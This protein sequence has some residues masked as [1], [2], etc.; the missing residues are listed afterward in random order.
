[1]YSLLVGID[2]CKDFFA[3]A[4]IDSEGEESFSRS[5]SMDSNG[6]GDFLKTIRSYC[7]DLSKVM[8]A[9]ESTGC[10]SHQSLFFS[11]IPGNPDDGRESLT[12]CQF[13]EAFASKDQDG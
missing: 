5:C 1:M 7:E 8:V 11:H 10:Y 2:V 12:D 9:M 13:C 6:F 3:T 4:G